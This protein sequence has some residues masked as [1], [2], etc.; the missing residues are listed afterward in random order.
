MGI[1]INFG[2]SGRIFKCAENFHKLAELALKQDNNLAISSACIY[3]LTAE[4]YLKSLDANTKLKNQSSGTI[5]DG[6]IYSELRGHKLDTLLSSVNN[7]IIAEVESYFSN[8][9]LNIENLCLEC[10][11]YFEHARYSY[12]LTGAHVYDVTKVKL[13]ADNLRSSIYLAH[14]IQPPRLV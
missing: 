2:V 3:G 13:L 10:K 6:E 7:P 5:T 11:D 14:K 9:N 8:Q 4:L 12:E 1:I